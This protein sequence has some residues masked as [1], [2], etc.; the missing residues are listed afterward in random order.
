MNTTDLKIG[1][2]EQKLDRIINTIKNRFETKTKSISENV[3]SFRARI[4]A[5]EENQ[6]HA[7]EGIEKLKRSIKEYEKKLL[8]T[9]DPSI[10]EREKE[11]KRELEDRQSQA[12]KLVE[13]IGQLKDLIQ[14][15]QEE[16]KS[17][18]IERKSTQAMFQVRG[19]ITHTGLSIEPIS[20]DEEYDRIRFTYRRL[21]PARPK[22]TYSFILNIA[23]SSIYSGI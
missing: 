22:I 19:C 5:L 3:K 4:N 16:R 20:E 21:N 1:E 2:Y 12:D 7:V 18:E 17:V 6:K 15:M 10:L 11:L 14:K 9:R 8:E 13:A 23:E